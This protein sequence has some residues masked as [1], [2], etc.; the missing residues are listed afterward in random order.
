MCSTP[1]CPPAELGQPGHRIAQAEGECSVGTVIGL[2]VLINSYRELL[3]VEPMLR[4]CLACRGCSPG[5]RL[6][7]PRDAFARDEATCF[8]F[9]LRPIWC[10]FPLNIMPQLPPASPALLLQRLAGPR[11]INLRGTPACI[12]RSSHHQT[13]THFAKRRTQLVEQPPSHRKDGD[14]EQGYGVFYQRTA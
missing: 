4:Q 8:P 9:L 10:C 13:Q 2:R 11:S 3:P 12:I 14:D 6:M 1:P 7:F 5:M